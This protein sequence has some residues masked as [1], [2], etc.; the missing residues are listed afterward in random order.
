MY[1]ELNFFLGTEVFSSIAIIMA[2]LRTRSG[3]P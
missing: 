3:N 1:L 2:L